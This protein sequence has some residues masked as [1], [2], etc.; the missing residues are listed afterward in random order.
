LY[1]IEGEAEIQGALSEPTRI[2]RVFTGATLSGR[3]EIV[4]SVTVH[5]GGTLDGSHVSTKALTI[6][7]NL[8]LKKGSALSVDIGRATHAALDVAGTVTNEG[9][10]LQLALVE[11]PRTGVPVTL[12]ASDTAIS[13]PFTT[14]NGAELG[15]NGAFILDYQGAPF[16]FVLEQTSTQAT[17]TCTSRLPTLISI[18]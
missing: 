14:V 16:Q 10:D 13:A 15:P 8:R 11:Q 17:A 2:H 9:T 1:V 6:G 5:P 12:V 3:G 4:S 7:G 18:R